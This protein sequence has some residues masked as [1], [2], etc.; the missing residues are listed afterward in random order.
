ML[1]FRVRSHRYITKHQ[2]CFQCVPLLPP[3]PY[4]NQHVASWHEL[5]GHS[6]PWVRGDDRRRLAVDSSC[7]S[8]CHP[9]HHPQIERGGTGDHRSEWCCFCVQCRGERDQALDGGSI[10]VGITHCREFPCKYTLACQDQSQITDGNHRPFQLYRELASRNS[11]RTSYTGKA[12][13][14]DSAFSRRKVVPK[15]SDSQ[16]MLKPNGLVK[17]VS[18]IAFY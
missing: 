9:P 15:E 3:L 4:V 14:S 5:S 16:V 6:V 11:G 12:L 8:R 13:Q 7:P 17:K 18:R 2:H 1:G 10:L